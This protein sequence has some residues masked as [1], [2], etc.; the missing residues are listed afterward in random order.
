MIK[1]A[2]KILK[3][4]IFISDSENVVPTFYMKGIKKYITPKVEKNKKD[5]IKKLI[6][7]VK[8]VKIKKI[9]PLSDYDLLPLSENKF[10]FD[11]L[12][13][14][15]IISRP[16]IIKSCMNKKKMYFFC[17]ENRI[18][19]PESF[20][21][22]N[23]KVKLPL[24]KKKLYGSGSL[25]LNFIKEKKEINKIDFKKFFLQKKIDGTEYGIDIF[26]DPL[27]S[28]SR[29]CIKKKLLMRSGETDRCILVKD[30]KINI[31]AKKILSVTNHYGNMD[32]DI[33]KDKRGKIYLIDL[34]PRFG[35]GYPSTHISGMNF[36]KYILTNGKFFI[37]KNYKKLIVSK[38]IS[39]H[40]NK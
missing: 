17:K 1:Y 35:G 34:N 37:P 3:S 25:G 12:N 23:V 24:V 20:F 22:K 16:E 5:Y 29:I 21:S 4:K 9:I 14:D 31:F 32:C 11:R 7:I 39:I 28:L 30:K 8:K 26:N 33:I 40:S 38:G 36:L 10:L 18:N 6:S 13:C 19:T 2:I 27:K 15:V